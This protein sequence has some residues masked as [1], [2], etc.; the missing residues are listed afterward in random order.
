[1]DGFLFEILDADD[2]F[3]MADSMAEFQVK[4]DKWQYLCE[5]NSR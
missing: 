4:F 3:M 2:L 1:M 5:K